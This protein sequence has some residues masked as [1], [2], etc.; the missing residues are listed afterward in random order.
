MR[1]TEY[2]A[3]VKKE[4]RH[5]PLLIYALVST[6]MIKYALE[7]ARITT[8]ECVWIGTVSMTSRL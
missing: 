7:L 1:P 5:I 6:T 2:K 8:A 4:K 3:F